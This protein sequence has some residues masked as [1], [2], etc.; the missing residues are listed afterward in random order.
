[1]AQTRGT[2]PALQDNVAKQ[3]T[4]LIG[5]E[6]AELKRKYPRV[7]PKVS[8]DSKFK[9]FVTSAPFGDVPEKP[10]GTEYTTDL[11]QQANTKDVTPREWGLMFE[12]TETAD[13]DDQ[14]D[15]LKKKSKYLAFSMGR[16]EDKTAADVFNLGF[17]TQTTADGVALF[18]TAH[19]LKRGGTAK[20]RP[21][22]DADLSFTSLVQAFTDLATDTKIESGQLAEPPESYLL[23]VPPHLEMLAHRLVKSTGIPQSAE[24]DTNPLKDLRKIT[25][26]VWPDLTDTDAWF[27]V[28]MDKERNGLIYAERIPI[29]LKPVVEDPRTGNMLAR[30]RCRKTWDAL[31]WRNSYGTSGA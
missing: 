17:S 5:K 8:F 16:V 9:R 18:S 7:F 11:I 13:E 26:M 2:F 29:T 31:D 24:N 4:A 12:Y 28:P 6:V 20:N 25:V 3:I 30:I 27:L 14:Y 22:S 10:E 23:L 19:T 15:E 1:M 21:S